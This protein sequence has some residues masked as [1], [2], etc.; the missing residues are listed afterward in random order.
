M[1]AMLTRPT[2]PGRLITRTEH[3]PDEGWLSLEEHDLFSVIRVDAE[4]IGGNLATA[5]EKM[6]EWAADRGEAIVVAVRNE[7][8]LTG[9]AMKVLIDASRSYPEF[10]IAG[11]GPD[12]QHAVAALDPASRV[13]TAPD[14]TS[15]LRGMR[16]RA[17]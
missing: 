8:A 11:V 9:A 5:L 3:A 1:T 4:R 12:G 15:A 6:I 17:A 10:A 7:L 14:V 16:R 2:T 13:Q